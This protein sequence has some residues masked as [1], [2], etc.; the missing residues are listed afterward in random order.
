MERIGLEPG[1]EIGGYRIVNQLGSGA[2]GVVYRAI[3]G[4]GQPVAFKILRSSVI[5]ADELRVRLIREAAALR[6]VNHPAVAAM[7]DAETDADDTFIVTELIDGPTLDE[8]VADNGPLP[9]KELHFFGAR[10]LSALEAVHAANVVHRD[11][12]PN[13]ILMSKDGPVLIDF[14]IAHGM[15]DSR[16]TATGLVVGTPGYLAP[17]LINGD[18]PNSATDIWGWAA[19]LVFAATGRPPF[20]IGGF[21]TILSRAMSGKADVDGLDERIAVA[22]RGALAVRPEHRWS[23]HEV[24]EELSASAHDPLGVQPFFDTT[25]DLP[26]EQVLGT[27]GP[28]NPHDEDL[29]QVRLEPRTQYA[30]NTADTQV[31]NDGSGSTKVL[32][33]QPATDE[34][35]PPSIP[36]APPQQF[37][38]P[39]GPSGDYGTFDERSGVPYPPGQSPYSQEESPYPPSYDYAGYVRPTPRPRPFVIG[40]GALAGILFASIYPVQA[41]AAVIAILLVF[42]IVGVSWD[43][44][45]SRREYK[46]PSKREVLVASVSFPWHVV[47]GVVGLI[48]GL[49]IGLATFVIVGGSLWWLLDSGALPINIDDAASYMRGR[50]LVVGIAVFSALAL[51]WFGPLSRLTRQGGRVAVQGLFPGSFTSL[52]V[53]FLLAGLA[54]YALLMILNG[55]D[56]VWDPLQEP[57]SFRE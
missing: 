33:A 31:L 29:T 7:L 55:I 34:P 20:G 11:M 28:H 45:H 3:D 19:V 32:P 15:Q 48:P 6:R 21:E 5:D 40:I 46:G 12:K 27:L 17:E 49:L 51:M 39:P 36:A 37:G 9:P 13:N 2:M 57:P 14:G 25:E 26:P 53:A 54:L 30:E 22:L 10:L 52:I 4:G 8:Y 35:L 1:T 24:L 16:L 23:P 44:F 18:N 56:I 50:Q 43:A 47:R 38:R 41:G 42:R